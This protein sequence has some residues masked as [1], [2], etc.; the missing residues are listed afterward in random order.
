MKGFTNQKLCWICAP[1]LDLI[2]LWFKW[3]HQQTRW[4][5]ESFNSNG[6]ST[7][8]WRSLCFDWRTETKAITTEVSS[9]WGQLARWLICGCFGLNSQRFF[10]FLSSF[11]CDVS[12]KEC[13]E[14]VG[15]LSHGYR[16]EKRRLFS[17]RV[18]KQHVLRLK[19]ILS[20]MWSLA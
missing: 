20:K 15:A 8:S 12:I 4:R 14:P 17:I 18:T 6:R 10:N 16:A 13:G 11:C 1:K 7:N 2:R 5:L 9:L 3:E 19:V